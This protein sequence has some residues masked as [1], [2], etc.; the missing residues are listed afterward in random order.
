M[1]VPAENFATASAA[2]AAGMVANTIT[3]PAA[4]LKLIADGL[5]CTAVARSD[6]IEPSFVA[7]KSLNAPAIVS[8]KM[9]V[10]VVAPAAAEVELGTAVVTVAPATAVVAPAVVRTVV[11]ADPATAVGDD[12][13]KLRR[14][15]SIDWGGAARH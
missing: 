4:T 2:A 9:A 7:S 3:L 13:A 12:G 8:F 5:I 15:G 6:L 14:L 1:S 11:A 10:A